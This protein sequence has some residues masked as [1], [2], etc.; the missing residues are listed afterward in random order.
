MALAIRA[1]PRRTAR[2]GAEELAERFRSAA[3]R[4]GDRSPGLLA[5]PSTVTADGTLVLTLSEP[6]ALLEAILAVADHVRPIPTTFSA[7]VHRSRGETAG[8][9]ARGGSPEREDPLHDTVMAAEAATSIAL[10]G[11]SET[12]P[13][14]KRV[15]VCF[16]EPDGLLGSLIE[17]VLMA[18]DSMTERQR[19]IVT[20]ARSSET[21]QQVASHLD[22]SRQAVNQ[23]LAAAGWK[24][25][26]RAE[27]AIEARLASP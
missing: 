23:S 4:L 12:D 18:Y 20:L 9:A 19:Q 24:Q 27:Q 17:L 8:R 7:A 25:L 1:H 2:A 21:Q 6:A 14:G 16:A 5:G 3:A 13:A 10:S 22:I 15:I 11:A 26:R